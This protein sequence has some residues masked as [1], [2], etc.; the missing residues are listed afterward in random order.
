VTRMVSMFA[1]VNISTINYDALLNGW[2]AQNLQYNVV[3]DGGDST[4]CDGEDA[5]ANIITSNGWRVTDGGKDCPDTDGD[6]YKD[7]VD[8]APNIY[9]PDQSDLDGDGIGDVADPCPSDGS[10]SCNQDGSVASSIGPEGGTIATPDENITLDIPAGALDD[11][12]SISIT[13]MGSGFELGTNRGNSTAVYG[14]EL[15]PPGTVFSEPVTLTLTWPDETNDGIIDTTGEREMNLYIF[16]DGVAIT[17]KC[18]NEPACDQV[19]NTF[20]VQISSFSVVVIATPR[21]TN[22]FWIIAFAIVLFIFIM[23]NLCKHKPSD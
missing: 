2:N 7:N 22:P 13:D 6:G 15:S 1:G 9:N 20:S 16:K 4:F 18:R 23:V 11:H 12:T 19:A 14:F 21:N 5:R 10:D 8:N 3:F 17:D